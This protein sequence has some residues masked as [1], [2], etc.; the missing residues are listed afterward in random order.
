MSKFYKNPKHQHKIR[1]LRSLVNEARAVSCQLEEYAVS[2]KDICAISD[3]A[4][5]TTMLGVVDDM[6]KG[7]DEMVQEVNERAAELVE[8]ESEEVNA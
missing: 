6:V 2:E 3:F 4:T 1:R 7:I 8:S 5:T